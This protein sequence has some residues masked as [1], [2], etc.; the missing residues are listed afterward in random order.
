MNVLHDVCKYRELLTAF[1]FI[2][3]CTA[4]NRDAWLI[5]TFFLQWMREIPISFRFLC[6][7]TIS[8]YLF[9][10]NREINSIINLH[11]HTR[12]YMYGHR[13]VTADI[14]Y[15]LFR[16]KN[17]KMWMLASF[18]SYFNKL[19]GC[20]IDFKTHTRISGSIC[21]IEVIVNLLMIFD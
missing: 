21:V 12:T 20:Q 10:Q 14:V 17:F 19:C 1:N 18:A 16:S 3:Q 9:I 7:A 4:H 8:D 2:F 11:N 6:A 15:Y 5:R 13:Y